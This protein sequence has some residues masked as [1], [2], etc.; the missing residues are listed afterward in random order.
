MSDPSAA[1]AAWDVPQAHDRY[2]IR[3]WGAKHFDIND[4]GHVVPK[5]LLDAD[6][7][8]DLTD[9]IEEAKDCHAVAFLE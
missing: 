9:V 1:T 7:A 4:A 2:T 6:A 5:P 3:R 8:A